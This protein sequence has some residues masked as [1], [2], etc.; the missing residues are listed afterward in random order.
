MRSKILIKVGLFRKIATQI[1]I[2]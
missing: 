1:R 2:H